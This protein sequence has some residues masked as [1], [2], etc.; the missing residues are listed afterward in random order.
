MAIQ[1]ADYF[2]LIALSGKWGTAVLLNFLKSFSDSL[3]CI[4]FFSSVQIFR[5]IQVLVPMLLLSHLNS[6]Y[7][8]L[9]YPL[10]LC[11]NWLPIASPLIGLFLRVLVP[12][13]PVDFVPGCPFQCPLSKPLLFPV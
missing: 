1:M 3:C 4:S 2:D 11:S 7:G 9:R 8:F 6:H 10:E 13:V 12:L 5:P